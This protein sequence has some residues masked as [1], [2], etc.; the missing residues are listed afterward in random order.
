[1]REAAQID[2]ASPR[3]R[4]L[5]SIIRSRRGVP[6]LTVLMVTV[7]RVFDSPIPLAPPLLTNGNEPLTVHLYRAA[8]NGSSRYLGLGSAVSV[9]TIVLILILL[10]PSTPSSVKG[11]RA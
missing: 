6:G 4:H 10:S 9:L 2:G 7:V 1:M 5:F 3:Q 8:F 11:A